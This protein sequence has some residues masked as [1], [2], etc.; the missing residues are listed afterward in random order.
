[1]PHFYAFFCLVF[2]LL[3]ISASA[4]KAAP[5]ASEKLLCR[6]L[7]YL[8][9][10]KKQVAKDHWAAYGKRTVENEIRFYTEQGVYLVNPQ[11]QTLA[12]TRT[13]S[14]HC[15]GFKLFRVND[16]LNTSYQMFTN[17]ADGIAACN[18]VTVS[19][20]YIPDVK[21]TETWAMMVVHEQFHQYQTNHKPFQ[22]RAIAMLSGGQYLS[23]DSIRA[24]YNAN[25]AF[26]KAVNQENDLLLVCLQTDR[27]TAIDSM[28]TQLLRIRNERLASY[29][30]ATGFDLSVK[31]EFEQIA[32]AGTRYI[33][34]H[35]SN[36]FKKYPV[37][38]RLAAVDTSY[39]ANR[40]FANYSLEHEGQYLYKMGA[41][42][43]YALGFNSIRLVEKLG[44]PFKD[45]MYA[46]P[47][48]SFTKVF[49]AY[50]KKRF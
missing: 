12:E 20:R 32:E 19:R 18:D 16:S 13:E 43:Y 46:E 36:D 8:M 23:H 14:C 11:K 1:M 41:T 39:H 3:S 47:D 50:L 49:E 21:D 15:P 44:I 10:L 5:D 34:Y 48:Y 26:K 17:F 22:K 28:L 30:K 31:E 40:G 2:S 25:P 45:R 6:R 33:E 4:Q 7:N 27:K 29:K 9:A 42:Y 37:D 35:L 38:P 24:I